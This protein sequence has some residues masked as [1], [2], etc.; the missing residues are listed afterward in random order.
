MT[1]PN[2][3]VRLLVVLLGVALGACATQQGATESVV[4]SVSSDKSLVI[5][6]IQVYRNG[7]P[8]NVGPR[9]P[10]FFGFLAGASP[11]TDVS[12][13]EVEDGGKHRAS[14][15]DQ[16][17]WFM[18]ALPPATYTMGVRYYTYLF[19]TPARLEVPAAGDVLCVGTLHAELSAGASLAGAWSDAFGGFKY[20]EDMA[21]AVSEECASAPLADQSRMTTRLIELSSE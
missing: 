8:L 21:F 14:V 5:G 6:R 1:S 19:N 15:M 18:I 7:T 17:G 3:A 20:V 13:R 9:E 2:V 16:E 12:F 11:L 10:P 4:P